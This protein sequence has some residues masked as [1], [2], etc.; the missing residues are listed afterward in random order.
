MLKIEYVLTVRLGLSNGKKIDPE[1]LR[2]N[3]IRV[4]H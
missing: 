1:R 4:D 2:Q 3:L